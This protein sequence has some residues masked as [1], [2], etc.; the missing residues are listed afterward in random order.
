MVSFG[1]AAADREIGQLQKEGPHQFD[2]AA[3]IADHRPFHFLHFKVADSLEK[4]WPASR[5]LYKHWLSGWEG[6]HRALDLAD[7]T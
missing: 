1:G 6:A 3:I 2:E 7:K 5:L 4:K